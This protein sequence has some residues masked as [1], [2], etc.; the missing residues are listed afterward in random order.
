MSSATW[1][2][3]LSLYLFLVGIDLTCIFL[4]LPITLGGQN[5]SAFLPLLHSRVSF[6]EC[7]DSCVS[8]FCCPRHTEY[9]CLKYCILKTL[10]LFVICLSDCHP[11]HWNVASRNVNCIRS[12]NLILFFL[13]TALTFPYFSFR[14][15]VRHCHCFLLFRILIQLLFYSK[16]GRG[17]PNVLHNIFFRP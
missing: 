13:F 16:L 12:C 4:D 15:Q 1:P 8:P 17:I 2:Y 5:T 6:V 9:F 3:C 14:F 7:V 11:P 10:I